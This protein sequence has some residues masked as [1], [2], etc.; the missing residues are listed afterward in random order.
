MVHPPL[1]GK[2]KRKLAAF[3]NRSFHSFVFLFS[4]FFRACVSGGQMHIE[5][6]R[7]MSGLIAVFVGDFFENTLSNALD[8]ERKEGFFFF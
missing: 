4:F 5:V 2:V 7:I 6:A 8:G 1:K 3:H